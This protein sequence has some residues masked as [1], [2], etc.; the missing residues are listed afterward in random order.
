EVRRL[1]DEQ[2]ALR[3][4]AT[5]VGRRTSPSEVFASVAEEVGL[6][7]GVDVVNIVRN[8]LDDTATVVASWSAVGGTIPLG[9]QLP[10]G[11][12]SIIGSVARTGRPARIDSYPDVPSATT[13]V[14]EGVPIQAGVGAP[15]VVDGRVWGTVVALSV[16]AAPLPDSTEARLSGFT[17]LVA[18]AIANAHAG[19]QVRRLADEQA[20]LRRVATLVAREPSPPALFAAVA[21]EVALVLDVELANVLRYDGED[22]ATV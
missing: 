8:E 4:V 15:I 16:E 21:E 6:L 17:E 10:L 1:A 22:V 2:A 7:L 3:R 18:T 13:Y 11:G 9:S 5:L 20:A 14:V 12:P 19:A